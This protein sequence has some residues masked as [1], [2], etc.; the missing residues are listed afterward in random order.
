ME[1]DYP[2]P[3]P[4]RD[5]LQAALRL[6]LGRAELQ[7]LYQPL[8]DLRNGAVASLE[9]LVRWPQ[10][11]PGLSG[12]LGDWLLRRTCHDRLLWRSDTLSGS[13]L[14]VAINVAPWQMDDPQFG[15]AV[16]AVLAEYAIPPGALTL[17]LNE[18]TLTRDPA[19]SDA[20]LAG[21]KQLGACLTLDDFG[22]GDSCLGHLQRYPFDV[23]KIA[24]AC[25]AGVAQHAGDAAFCKAVIAMAH[26]LGLR[27][28]AR[29]VDSEAQCD[30]LRRHMCDLVQGAC[31]AP[32]LAPD[33]VAQLLRDDRRLPPHLLRTQA[34]RRSLLLVDDEKNI[35][36]S[37]KRLLR[38]DGYDLYSAASG[39]EG[40]ELLARLPIDVII[41]DQRMPG[42]SGADFLRQARVVR[43]ETIRIML[44]GYTE[45]Q[46]V[47]DAV[48]EGAIYKFLTKPW[49]DEQLRAHVGEAFR[50]KEIAD[51]NQRLHL[52]VRTANHELASAN[53]RME[54][55]LHQMQRQIHR[56]EISLSIA[57]EILQHLPL[58]VI[59]MD[60]AG[61]IAFINGAAERVFSGATLLGAEAGV[62]LPALL[63]PAGQAA[64]HHALIGGVRYAV[65]VYPMGEHSASRGSLITLSR[66]EENA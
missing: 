40:L 15:P 19:R 48:N 14:Q 23:I 43:P 29:G 22:S 26:N 57:R 11:P 8:V 55:L 37:L 33:A 2:G 32:P 59:G 52:E 63:P 4:L 50:L 9:A 56:D 46:S 53:R 49:N 30:F 10:P 39:E 16:A 64:G 45:L 21:F 12:A 66:F 3:A 47:T 20:V 27:V 54:Q 6:A 51:D 18:T 31:F 24:G 58:P 60:D 25:I 17:E 7:L 36:A 5:D 1:L 44:S 41:S 13:D 61:M 65:M 42:L 35:V 38:Q 28:A 62:A 34:R